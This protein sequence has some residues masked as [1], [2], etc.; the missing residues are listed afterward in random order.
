MIRFFL[1]SL[2]SLSACLCLLIPLRTSAQTDTLSLQDCI[3]LALRHNLQYLREYQSLASSQVQWQQARA[4]FALQIEADFT[5]PQYNESRDIQESV[6]LQTRIREESTD[7]TYAGNLRLTQRFPYVGRF[8]VIS[9]LLRR[10]FSSNRRASYLDVAGD[11]RL[12]YT[13]ELL[14]PPREELALRQA[15]LGL[16][17]AQYNFDR[18]R[19]LLEGEVIEAY[20]ALVQSLRQLEIEAQRLDQSKASLELA[21]R[22]FEIGLI[23]EVEALRLRVAMLRAEASF[24]RAKI[25]IERRRDLLRQI[26][27]LEPEQ[28]LEVRTGVEHRQYQIDPARALR[29]GLQQRTDLQQAEILEEIRRLN[30]AEARRQQGL[31]ATLNASVSLKGN[32]ESIDDISRTLGRNQWGVGIEVSLPLLDNGQGRGG[33]QQAEIALEQSRLSRQLRHQEIVQE[34]RESIRNL[35]EAERQISLRQAALEVAE[36]TYEIEQNRFEL[37][38]AQSQ[39][40]LDAQAEL[41]QAR[42]DA[43]EAIIDYQRQLKNLRLATM[44][45]LDQLVA[46]ATE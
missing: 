39:N 31:S 37:G 18:Q 41:T 13:H 3:D 4:P 34:I 27:G 2:W 5:L 28:P 26:L 22:K 29:I 45:E 30:L 23:A 38:L 33:I 46:P 9:T 42:F 1:P 25:Q 19:L 10:D 21:Q 35:Q 40:L 17:S 20:Y 14:H 24:A 32:G 16:A 36:R 44:A 12:N 43:L 11:L 15:E 8:D 7:F 6:A